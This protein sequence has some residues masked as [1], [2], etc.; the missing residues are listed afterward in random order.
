MTFHYANPGNGE[1]LAVFGDE[2]PAES[3]LYKTVTINQDKVSTVDYFSKAG[4]KLAT[5]ISANLDQ[6]SLETLGSEETRTVED[7]LEGEVQLTWNSHSTSKG[8]MFTDPTDVTFDYELLINE[9][10]HNCIDF[11]TTCDYEVEINIRNVEGIYETVTETISVPAAACGSTAGNT[12][13]TFSIEL[14]PG[15][16]SIEWCVKTGSRQRREC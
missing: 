10:Q 12:T 5:C 4:Q 7:A 13:K 9:M 11:C 15:S 6:Q 1:L 2:T 16:Y 14:M 8:L 3:E